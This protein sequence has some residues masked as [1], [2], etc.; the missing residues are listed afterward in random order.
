MQRMRLRIVTGHDTPRT[1]RLHGGPPAWWRAVGAA[2]GRRTAHRLRQDRVLANR[3]F[4]FTHRCLSGSLNALATLARSGLLDAALETF[5]RHHDSAIR[6]QYAVLP[7]LQDNEHAARV[8]A[9]AI[10]RAPGRRT[11]GLDAAYRGATPAARLAAAAAL[12]AARYWLGSRGIRET[13]PGLLRDVCNG[14]LDVLATLVHSGRKHLTHAYWA[15]GRRAGFTTRLQWRA[16]VNG[17]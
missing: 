16:A 5:R 4:R 13:L 11:Y 3:L 15:A 14:S 6:Q 17:Q 7:G 8:A 12:T 10:L 1:R 9:A 2:L